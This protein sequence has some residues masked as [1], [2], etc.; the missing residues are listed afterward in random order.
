MGRL[1]MAMALLVAVTW[2]G[3]SCGLA[4]ETA[5]GGPA[6][7]A[8]EVLASQNLEPEESVPLERQWDGLLTAARDAAALLGDDSERA[9]AL[10]EAADRAVSLHAEQ[11]AEAVSRLRSAVREVL[12]DLKFRPR[13][14]ADLPVGFPV[15]APA[16]ELVVKQ[17]PVYRLARTAMDG[18]AFWSLFG[19]I[20][21]NDIAMTAPVEMQYGTDSQQEAVSTMAFLYGRTDLG[22]PGADGRVE[23][24]DLPATT[25]ISMGVRGGRT[26]AKVRAARERLERWL[27]DNAQRY[28][29]AGPLRVMSYNSPFMPQAWQFFEVEIP[30]RPTAK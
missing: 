29:P 1:T 9:R 12:L 24:V 3:A 16:G 17:Y 13:M 11:P 10:R 27:A 6:D 20:K 14:E 8:A 30:I 28:E 18:G 26:E 21:K 23:V 5:S 22:S 4:E 2:W 7:K 19:H 25:T 15:P